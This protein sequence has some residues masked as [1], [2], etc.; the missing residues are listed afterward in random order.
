MV[1]LGMCVHPISLTTCTCGYGSKEF[2]YL[3]GLAPSIIVNACHNVCYDKQCIDRLFCSLDFRCRFMS[4]LGYQFRS[5]SPSTALA[6]LHQKHEQQQKKGLHFC[7][8]F[9][10]CDITPPPPIDFVTFHLCRSESQRA[11]VHV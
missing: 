6:L 7:H 11:D 10:A 5:F 9:L 2:F 1:G 4:L 8:C 3:C